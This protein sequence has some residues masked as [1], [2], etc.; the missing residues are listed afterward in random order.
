V[1]KH[2][3][4][5]N[6]R[7]KFTPDLWAKWHARR[8]KPFPELAKGIADFRAVLSS[9]DQVYEVKP[10]GRLHFAPANMVRFDCE[11]CGEKN[12]LF[13]ANECIHCGHMLPAS[14]IKPTQTLTERQKKK[15][16]IN[17]GSTWN[18]NPEK[19]PK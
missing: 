8:N 11:G 7:I 4:H 10:T 15:W 2:H 9:Y 5:D 16:S 14:N 1:G 6:D 18:L 19:L 3:P 17:P 12:S 13:K